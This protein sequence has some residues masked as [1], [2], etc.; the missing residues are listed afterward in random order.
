LSFTEEKVGPE[1][2]AGQDALNDGLVVQLYEGTCADKTSGPLFANLS[3]FAVHTVNH[4][5]YG[6]VFQ[7]I[8]PE[9]VSARMALLG[10]PANT[11]GE[12]S[13]NLEVTGLDTMAI[14]LGDGNP[15]A[16]VLTDA[17]G[18]A[19]GCIDVDNAIVGSQIPTPTRKVRRRVRR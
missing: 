16:L 5:S 10:M 1:C 6:T 9:T 15:F 3:P 17:S 4:Q 8:A 11:C 18:I 19:T 13:L 12:W 2:L 7:S 14:G